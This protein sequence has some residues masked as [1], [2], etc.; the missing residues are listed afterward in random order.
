MEIGDVIKL[1]VVFFIIMCD[2]VVTVIAYNVHPK[3]YLFRSILI[4]IAGFIILPASWI[5][6]L[7]EVA[8]R[9]R[10]SKRLW[11]SLNEQE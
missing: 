3:G 6:W 11:E 5:N 10:M 7:R 8:Y 4:G 1:V 2:I 9:K